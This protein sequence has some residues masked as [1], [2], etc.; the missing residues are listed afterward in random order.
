[1]QAG[2]FWEEDSPNPSGAQSKEYAHETTISNHRQRVIKNKATRGEISPP[3][4]GHGRSSPAHPP[5]ATT[6]R[7]ETAQS[8]ETRRR[9]H[10]P[11][12]S[13]G[14]STRQKAQDAWKGNGECRKLTEARKGTGAAA[15]AALQLDPAAFRRSVLPPPPAEPSA[16]KA[17]RQLDLHQTLV[18]PSL[19]LPPFT[20]GSAQERQRVR[21]ARKGADRRGDRPQP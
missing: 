5:A 18:S 3:K 1:M 12:I 19:P 13:A 11:P 7:K 14:A 10:E 9:N 8:H 6:A 20:E 2:K 4:Q 16:K 15:A 21:R 17:A